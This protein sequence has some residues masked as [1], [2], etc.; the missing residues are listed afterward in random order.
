MEAC[1]TVHDLASDQGPH[2]C[3]LST[4]SL[5]LWKYGLS[6][7]MTLHISLHIY[8]SFS[9]LGIFYV[10]Y[11]NICKG[12]CQHESRVIAFLKFVVFKI[13]T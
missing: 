4:L 12:V 1:Q 7:V 11:V 13:L 2:L 6:L 3:S 9:L 10:D 8:S 5:T